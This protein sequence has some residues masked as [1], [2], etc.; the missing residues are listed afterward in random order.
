VPTNSPYHFNYGK[1]NSIS[2]GVRP[3]NPRTDAVWAVECNRLARKLYADMGLDTPSANS[4]AAGATVRGI[5][6]EFA[7]EFE[8]THTFEVGASGIPFAAISVRLGLLQDPE[9]GA[10]IICGFIGKQLEALIRP[11][12]Q[13]PSPEVYRVYQSTLFLSF[14]AGWANR[15]GYSGKL[16]MAVGLLSRNSGMVRIK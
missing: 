15:R 8:P 16:K 10:V 3:F 7:S 4:S 11:E 5:L 13:P 14:L 2:L 1:P 9:A 6:S 12:T